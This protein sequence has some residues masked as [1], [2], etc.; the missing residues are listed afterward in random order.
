MIGF[1]FCAQTVKVNPRNAVPLAGADKHGAIIPPLCGCRWGLFAV[2]HRNLTPIFW[3]FAH[4]AENT[5]RD[6]N[7]LTNGYGKSRNVDPSAATHWNNTAWSTHR[8]FVAKESHNSMRH[9]CSPAVPG[10]HVNV[11][12]LHVD[13]TP[14]VIASER[15]YV[16]HSSL[17]DEVV[18]HLFAKIQI[19]INGI[20]GIER[21]LL[22]VIRNPIGVR[23][24]RFL[25]PEEEFHKLY[26]FDP[27][28]PDVDRIDT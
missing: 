27:V 17:F 24:L 1:Y 5:K 8:S 9:C 6:I 7:A 10:T 21:G 22:C 26:R 3:I 4:G 20:F 12:P 16:Q 15:G 28:Q 19:V 14:H 25:A 13:L 18:A 2:N 23:P 11:L